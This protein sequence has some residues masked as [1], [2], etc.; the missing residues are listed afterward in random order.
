MAKRTTYTTEFKKQA[1]AMLETRDKSIVELARF[2]Y[3]GRRIF[4][5]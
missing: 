1:V 5:K 3:T 4:G 2:F